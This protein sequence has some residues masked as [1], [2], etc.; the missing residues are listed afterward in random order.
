MKA[1]RNAPTQTWYEQF[2]TIGF[3]NEIAY[4]EVLW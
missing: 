2:R 1:K 3:E 4:I